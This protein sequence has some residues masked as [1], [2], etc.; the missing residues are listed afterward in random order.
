[1]TW[2]AH[3]VLRRSSCG[4]RNCEIRESVV[5]VDADAAAGLV[6]V[7]IPLAAG[8]WVEVFVGDCG[9]SDGVALE[10]VRSAAA[11]RTARGDAGVVRHRARA[12]ATWPKRE[13]VEDRGHRH[14]AG[15]G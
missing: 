11:A 4:R 9:A 3:S 15:R 6:V 8:R 7:G 5:A 12:T 14:R 13:P 10:H 2:T 1:M